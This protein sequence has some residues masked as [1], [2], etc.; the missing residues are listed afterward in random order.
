MY[1]PNDRV[2]RCE[3]NRFAENESNASYTN[4]IFVRLSAKDRT[5]ARVNFSFS[6]FDGCYLRGCKFLDCDFT[7]CRFLSTN[8]H[9]STFEI[10]NFRY[11]VFEKTQIAPDILVTQ[12]PDHENLRASIRPQSTHKLPAA[13]GRS[14]SKQSDQD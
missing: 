4:H 5:F 1:S 14:G 3:D 13:R 10:C 9:N 2:V 12:A 6:T 7:G 8:F 11:A